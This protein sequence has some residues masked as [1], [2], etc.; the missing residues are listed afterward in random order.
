MVPAPQDSAPSTRRIRR[1]PEQAEREILHAAD[2]LLRERNFR[3]VSV[4]DLMARTGLKRSSFYVHFRDRNHVV[5]PLLE[6]AERDLYVA[7]EPWMTGSAHPLDDLGLALQRTVNAF[8]GHGHVL[9]GAAE[10]AH[11]DDQVEAAYD[12]VRSDS[13]EGITRRLRAEKRRSGMDLPSPEIVAEAL[14]GMNEHMLLG[15]VRGNAGLTGQE[16][17]RALQLVWVRSLY[18]HLA[19]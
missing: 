8:V 13:V 18:P 12:R 16:V 15:L 17:V 9:R 11:H 4:E 5:L 1:R 19:A 3:D 6:R 14:V 7:A 2:L 10:A